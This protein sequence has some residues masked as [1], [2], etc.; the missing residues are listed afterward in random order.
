MLGR[1]PA[2]MP[3]GSACKA[4]A[5]RL[6]GDGPIHRDRLVP[7]RPAAPRSSGA[8]RMRWI[9]S[10][11]CCRCSWSTTSHPR[12]GAGRAP[13]GA[14]S[15]RARSSSLRSEL[16]ERDSQLADRARRSGE[17]GGRGG[18]ARSAPGRW[19]RAATSRRTAGV[20]TM[21]VGERLG[22]ARHPA[23][24]RPR[25]P[26][27]RARRGPPRTA[28][29][30]SACSRHSI[31]AGWSSRFARS[32]RRPRRIP[33]VTLPPSLA[34]ASTS[35]H[36]SSR[37]HH[38]DRG[39]RAPARAHG[40]GGAR[41]AR[42]LGRLGRTSRLRHRPRPAGPRRNVATQPGPALG[43]ALAGRGPGAHDG[44]RP[45]ARPATGRSSP[46]A[47]STP[48][49]CGTSRRWRAGHS[50]RARRRR[51]VEGRGRDRGLEAGPDR[52]PGR[53]C[54][55]APAP[56]HRLD[57]QPGADAR[58]LVPDEAPR[59]RLAGGGG[60]LHGAPR[61]RRPGQQQRRLAVGRVHRDGPAAVLPDLQP[62][63]PGPAARSQRRLRPALGARAGARP[64][65][66]VP[67]VH[68]PPDGAYLPRIV[69]HA[70]ARRR[71]LAA[72]E[73][74]RAPV[75]SDGPSRARRPPR[76]GRPASVSP[77]CHPGPAA[78]P[79][80]RARSPGPDRRPAGAERPPV[81]RSGRARS[82]RRSPPPMHR[83]P[84]RPSRRP[85]GPGRGSSPRG[86]R[87]AP[88]PRTPGRRAR[89]GRPA[90]APTMIAADR[91]STLAAASS[92]CPRRRWTALLARCS[93]ATL[94]RPDAQASPS[95][96]SAGKSRSSA[97]RSNEPRREQLVEDL[98][99]PDRVHRAAAATNRS[100]R[101]S[102]SARRRSLPPRRATGTRRGSTARPDSATDGPVDD[103]RR[104][105]A[106]RPALRR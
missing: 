53:G 104:G 47:T 16:R 17:R 101:S 52:L 59:R 81:P 20:A 79:A 46:G 33:T 62:D 44:R 34:A 76:E 65:S 105:R 61:R 21:A 60:P 54:G 14:G 40:A 49:C 75:L 103:R 58:R 37:R 97:T 80:L 12:A 87:A 45:R 71:A 98:V 66:T 27:P 42:S 22:G 18:G 102:A 31:A 67:T 86:R 95:R 73:S 41:P 90:A 68:E 84:R 15:S 96:R 94:T 6:G 35:T 1:E 51:L 69:D 91:S 43:P 2:P 11:G 26:G 57:A 29:A 88:Q 8:R 70:S 64:G 78:P 92:A 72:Y 83:P 39:S 36:A 55:D 48:T 24:R 50:A 89:A 56:R 19:S 38:A 3:G 13:I 99:D 7:S 77:R 25:R 82:R 10:S 74:A 32:C 28:A 5:D 63:A 23:G 9:G 106:R 93:P 100:P 4:P 85:G 30:R